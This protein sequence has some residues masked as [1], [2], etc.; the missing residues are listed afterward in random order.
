VK[1]YPLNLYSH[2]L[3]N[4][5]ACNSFYPVR[6]KSNHPQK[7]IT[8][9][10]LNSNGNLSSNRAVIQKLQSIDIAVKTH[11]KTH[12]LILGGYASSG[13]Q[14]S[15]IILPSGEKYA[16]GGSVG[17]DLK[18][19]PGNPEETIRKMRIIRSAALGP[20]TPSSPDKRIAAK[21]YQLEMQAQRELERQKLE[22]NKSLS[23]GVE[24]YTDGDFNTMDIRTVPGN[25]E[26][27]IR[28][29]EALRREIFASG[30]ISFRNMMVLARLYLLEIQAHKEL[31]V[32]RE[33]GTHLVDIYV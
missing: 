32:Q 26:E 12:Q 9:R 2:L 31:D 8:A 6:K 4:N 7:E 22:G 24:L 33:E 5:S 11:E 16:I 3:R 1:V 27:T 15:Y 18:P 28:K 20:L 21:A 10:T 25:P 30:K 29:A 19:V 17:V 13:I 14:Y 23:P